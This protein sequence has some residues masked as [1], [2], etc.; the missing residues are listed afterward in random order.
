MSRTVDRFRIT[1]VIFKSISEESYLLIL[2]FLQTAAA[3]N[4]AII[5]GLKAAGKI[6]RR[7]Y[8]YVEFIS[9]DKGIYR[10]GTL[11]VRFR[12]GPLLGNHPYDIRRFVNKALDFHNIQCQ[13]E[14]DYQKPFRRAPNSGRQSVS[15]F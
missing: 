15:P 7:R 6:S 13:F 2:D 12:Y 9:F 5:E 10:Q 4:N 8:R 14:L 11:Q 1:D 3:K